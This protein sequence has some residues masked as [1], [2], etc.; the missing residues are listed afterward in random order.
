MTHFRGEVPR[1]LIRTSTKIINALLIPGKVPS[2]NVVHSMVAFWFQK[3]IINDFI[4]SFQKIFC[5]VDVSLMFLWSEMIVF[6]SH[7]I[8][9]T[10][11]TKITIPTSICFFSSDD[12]PTFLFS[13]LCNIYLYI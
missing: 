6:S 2:E 13:T 12:C 10:I 4:F 5:D 8:I 9:M 1:I 7:F 3:I 11:T